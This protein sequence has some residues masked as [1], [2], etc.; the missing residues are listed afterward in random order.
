MKL[1][2]EEEEEDSVSQSESPENAIIQAYTRSRSDPQEKMHSHRGKSAS[3]DDNIRTARARDSQ[4]HDSGHRELHGCGELRA[5]ETRHVVSKVPKP[6]IES[7][8]GEPTPCHTRRHSGHDLRSRESLLSSCKLLVV[9]ACTANDDVL[10]MLRDAPC[11][12]PVT[13]ETLKELD[14]HYIQNNINLR[15]DVH[16]DHDLHFMPISGRRGQEK[17]E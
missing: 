2:D 7:R 10:H 16:F 17:R 13:T 1:G 8:P 5:Q 9:P 14:L 3:G 15:V 4:S 6:S 12:P 11:R